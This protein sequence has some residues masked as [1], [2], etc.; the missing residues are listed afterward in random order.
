LI[1]LE[2]LDFYREKLGFKILGYVIMSDHFHYLIFWNVEKKEFLYR[3][4]TGLS[5]R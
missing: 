5:R 3:V 2:D 4:A 1:L